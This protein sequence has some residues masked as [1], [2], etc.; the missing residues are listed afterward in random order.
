VTRRKRR[1]FSTEYKTEM[2]E[3][4]RKSGLSMCAFA[5]QIDVAESVFRSWVNEANAQKTGITK[6]GLTLRERE[7]LNKLRRKVKTLEMER[8]ILKKATAFFARES[9]SDTASS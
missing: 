5:K 3:T 4:W 1:K 9:K 7:E 6:G 8:D 2:V